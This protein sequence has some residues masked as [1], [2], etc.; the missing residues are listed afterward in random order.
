[1]KFYEC[2]TCGNIM[3]L[4]E[5]SGV[6][7]MCCGSPMKDLTPLVED[8]GKEKHVPVI[9]V[10]GNTVTIKVGDTP[11]PMMDEHY[12][13]WIMLETNMG[14][15]KR[16]LKPGMEPTITFNLVDG[17]HPV[18]AYEYCNIHSLWSKQV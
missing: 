11:H 17:E 13:K 9:T 5:D 12:V 2:K 14:E 3:V 10:N 8:N 15:Y 4:F 18:S 6:I 1:M 7:P 16:Y